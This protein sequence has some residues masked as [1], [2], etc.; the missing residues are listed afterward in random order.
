M[1]LASA[2]RPAGCPT[3]PGEIV[4]IDYINYRGERAIRRVIPDRCYLGE[5]TW[6]PGMQWILDAWDIDK[7]AIRSFAIADIQLW[8][9]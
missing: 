3:D 1:K 6:H 7:G 5:V 8:G 9:V 4:R 2:Q